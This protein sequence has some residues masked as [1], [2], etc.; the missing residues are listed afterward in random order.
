MG[1]R[2]TV[3]SEGPFKGRSLPDQGEYLLLP[4]RPLDT[5]GP[6]RPLDAHDT[7]PH[8]LVPITLFGRAFSVWVP[9][10]VPEHQLAEYVC[11]QL[12]NPLGYGLWREGDQIDGRA[13]QDNDRARTSDRGQR[14]EATRNIR[15]GPYRPDRV[16]EA[17]GGHHRPGAGG[18]A[19]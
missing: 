17:P 1:T 19:H 6:L 2:G 18:S 7:N 4:N 9:L 11:S 10:D 5:R 12:M 16:P 13:E 14:E 15:T 8:R 3:L